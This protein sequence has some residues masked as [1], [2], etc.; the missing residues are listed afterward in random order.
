MPRADFVRESA[1]RRRLRHA[2]T[3]IE[4]AGGGRPFVVK[5]TGAAGKSGRAG[6]YAG[7]DGGAGGAGGGATASASVVN[8]SGGAQAY[9]RAGRGGRAYGA[10]GATVAGLNTTNLTITGTTAQVDAALATLTDTEAS[11]GADTITLDATDTRSGYA[12]PV[13]IAVTVDG[14]GARTAAAHR[15]VSAMAGLAAH[16]GASAEH[17]SS[18][19]RIDPDRHLIAARN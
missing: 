12:E 16:T 14:D 17:L 2:R 19:T 7:D 10:G 18:G 8:G 11:N 4:Q 3:E 13:N 15:L 5:V 1:A 9:A 6:Q